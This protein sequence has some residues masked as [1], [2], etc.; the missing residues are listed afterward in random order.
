MIA[1]HP[2]NHKA[3]F[4]A[5]PVSVSELPKS[6]EDVEPSEKALQSTEDLNPHEEDMKLEE[7][8][9]LREQSSG[10]PSDREDAHE[11]ASKSAED[12][13]PDKGAL[14]S[15]KDLNPHG[16][17]LKLG[18]DLKLREKASTPPPDVE[19]HEGA[20]NSVEA[21]KLQR[22]KTRSA[23]KVEPKEKATKL[24]QIPNVQGKTAEFNEDLKPYEQAFREAASIFLTHWKF[25]QPVVRGAFARYFTPTTRKK[26]RP[27][28]NPLGL[29]KKH[30]DAMTAMERPDPSD[31]ET[32]REY[33]LNLLLL[34]GI[35]GAAEESLKMLEELEDLHSRTKI[36]VPILGLGR[37]YQ[38]PPLEEFV[39]Q[40]QEDGVTFGDFVKGKLDLVPAEAA[41]GVVTSL[42]VALGNSVGL[43]LSRRLG[44]FSKVLG[45]FDSVALRL[46]HPTEEVPKALLDLFEASIRQDAILKGGLASA[47]EKFAPFLAAQGLDV[48]ATLHNVS[49]LNLLYSGK[50]FDTSLV[51]SSSRNGGVE[52]ADDATEQLLQAGKTL[53]TTHGMYVRLTYYMT[54]S[55]RV[56]EQLR[57]RRRDFMKLSKN[58][59]SVR[60]TDDLQSLA[61][62]L[63]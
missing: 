43:D 63:I 12:V 15:T 41:G 5:K 7:D 60:E 58:G 4:Q 37:S 32:C 17:T 1:L 46:M 22:R 27:D 28:L 62:F 34:T 52:D 53:W 59:K 48:T 31:V 14:P 21:L 24:A 38:L 6:A 36:P 25:S 33:K 26:K 45:L 49:P 8:L 13:E 51:F 23:R 57:N 42:V 3:Y 40:L 9:K 29:F 47:R 56:P 20:S 35:C 16:E 54:E 11:G 55:E 10:L 19:S 61:R 2:L 30:I 18:E 39:N 50:I 44:P